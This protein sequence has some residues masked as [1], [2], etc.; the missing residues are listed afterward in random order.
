MRILVLGGSGFIGRAL[1][2]QLQRAGHRITVPTRRDRQWRGLAALPAVQVVRGDVLGEAGLLESLLPGHDAVVN[3]I[4]ILHGRPV[5]F[6]R[7]HVQWPHRLGR[8]C[9]QAGIGQLVHVSA[10]GVEGGEASGSDYLRSKARGETTLRALDGLPLTLMRPSV[11]F[12]AG[13]QFLNLF[14]SLQSVFPLLPLGGASARMQPVW[15]EDVATA[16]LRS[17]EWREAIG[18]TYELAGPEIKTLRELVQLAGRWAGCARSVLPLPAPLAYLQAQFMEWLPGPLLSRDNLRSL[19]VP[20]V[21]TGQLPGLREL[22]VQAHSLAEVV[23]LYLAPG[24]A[25]ARLDELRARR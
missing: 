19:R 1:C 7:L 2:E 21:A 5:D 10:L 20:N 18:Q 25:E 4:A 13:D 11:V 15:V 12:G 6:E 3:L 24:Q 8:A 23:P 16:L 17:L 9:V 14:A 22:G